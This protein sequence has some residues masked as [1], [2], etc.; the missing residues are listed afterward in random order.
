M[1][2]KTYIVPT[3]GGYTPWHQVADNANPTSVGFLVGLSGGATGAVWTM[4]YGFSD[5]NANH[6]LHGTENL[7]TG[8]L[9]EP[10]TALVSRTTTV[11][12]VVFQQD[13]AIAPIATAS[14]SSLIIA[15]SNTALDN[16]PS[17][18]F[19]GVSW[20]T[21]TYSSSTFTATFPTVTSGTIASNNQAYVQII[22][23]QQDPTLVA[24]T[25]GATGNIAFPCNYMRMFVSALT[26]GSMSLTVN[27][28]ES[29]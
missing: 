12:S 13:V 7:Y 16:S 29:R 19:P 9:F 2:T 23:W 8:D 24:Q 15:G 20:E 3:G 4:Q 27:Q 6:I 5:R 28:A 14:G 18:T 21:A 22:R 11:G 17:G 1:R 10:G 25:A 26:A